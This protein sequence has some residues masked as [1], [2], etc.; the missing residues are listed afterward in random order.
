MHRGSA[1]F[2]R[3]QKRTNGGP[4]RSTGSWKSGGKCQTFV[5]I[6]AA[7]VNRIPPKIT[8]H[9]L[10]SY[11]KFPAKSTFRTI[12]FAP[13]IVDSSRY[14]PTRQF[15]KLSY[16]GRP[17]YDIRFYLTA[18]NVRE[19]T[20]RVQ[21]LKREFYLARGYSGSGGCASEQLVRTER[22]RE[23]EREGIDPDLRESFSEIT[24]VSRKVSV[25]ATIQA[26]LCAH[27]TGRPL[28]KQ[29]GHEQRQREM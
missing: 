6:N 26:G 12:V 4:I 13:P 28:C 17:S 7:Q 14:S 3:I 1:L 24:P 29:L 25:F 2:V 5:P 10:L 21:D 11:V 22:R 19:A 8:R 27:A 23:R 20:L 18:Y 16:V 9:R 15:A